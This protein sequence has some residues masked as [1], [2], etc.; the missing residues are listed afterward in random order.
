MQGHF[1]LIPQGNKTIEVA[2]L[3]VLLTQ[4]VPHMF[5]W[6]ELK[7]R[8]AKV[9]A[10]CFHITNHLINAISLLSGFAKLAN[11][12]QKFDYAVCL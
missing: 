6:I 4:F 7:G 2:V 5:D 12:Y 10:S 1:G 11:F 9:T 3:E 8:V